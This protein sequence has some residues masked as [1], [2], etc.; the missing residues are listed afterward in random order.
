M[1]STASFYLNAA[2][3]YPC[4]LDN[5]PPPIFIF[6]VSMSV[7]MCVYKIWNWRCTIQQWMP[8]PPGKGG[9]LEMAQLWVNLPSA[10]KMAPPRYQSL[11]SDQIPVVPL[12]GVSQGRIL[13]PPSCSFLLLVLFHQASCFFFFSCFVA[14]YYLHSYFTQLFI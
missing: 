6:N 7:C 12:F 11:L 3:D 10:H 9:V 4:G 1:L 8:P 5:I 13:S 2:N 14:H